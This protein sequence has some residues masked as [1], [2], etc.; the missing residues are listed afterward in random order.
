[1]RHVLNDDGLDYESCADVDKHISAWDDW[2][3]GLMVLVAA[4]YD[5]NTQNTALKFNTAW[6]YYPS[7]SGKTVKRYAVKMMA[8]ANKHS[9]VEFKLCCSFSMLYI[10][11][12]KQMTSVRTTLSPWLQ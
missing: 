11:T 8:V 3:E 1:M 12:Y 2:H 6:S 5:D 7:G 9:N 4:M 10:R